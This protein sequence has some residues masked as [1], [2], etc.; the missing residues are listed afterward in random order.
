[1]RKPITEPE[2]WQEEYGGAALPKVSLIQ[3]RILEYLAK[4]WPSK[5]I[6]A[7]L[8]MTESAVNHQK[9]KLRDKFNVTNSPA[10]VFATWEYLRK[11]KAQ[12]AAITK[13]KRPK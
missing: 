12:Q 11:I 13:S 4:G 7:A 2:A 9:E 8:G 1:M 6:A 3:Y 10:L 5:Q